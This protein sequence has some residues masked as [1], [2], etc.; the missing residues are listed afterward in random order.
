[1]LYKVNTSTK[2]TWVNFDN[3]ALHCYCVWDNVTTITVWEILFPSFDTSHV[4]KVTILKVPD[5]IF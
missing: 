4:A 3:R 5:M 2:V 1:M